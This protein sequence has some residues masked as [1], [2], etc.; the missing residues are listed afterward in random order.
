[1]KIFQ[2]KELMKHINDL[3]V[4]IVDI[5]ILYQTTFKDA[6]VGIY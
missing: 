2:L 1:M 4:E 3:L 6:I 5:V